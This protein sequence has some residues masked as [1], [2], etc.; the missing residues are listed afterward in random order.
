MRSCS[1]PVILLK[2][3]PDFSHRLSCNESLSVVAECDSPKFEET[4]AA[5]KLMQAT[6]QNWSGSCGTVFYNHKGKKSLFFFFYIYQLFWRHILT[7]VPAYWLGR[8]RTGNI[9]SDLCSLLLA[10]IMAFEFALFSCFSSPSPSPALLKDFVFYKSVS[11]AL[12]SWISSLICARHFVPLKLHFYISSQWSYICRLLLTF[13]LIK[14][15]PFIIPLSYKELWRWGAQKNGC[16]RLNC[17]GKGALL[18]ANE[19][20][21]HSCIKMIIKNI[22]RCFF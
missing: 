9:L 3:F 12:E 15:N 16:K 2:R 17:L 8:T 1:Y 20:A 22:D 6:E 10:W 7:K 19:D 5:V 4:A 14:L 21:F 18:V 11:L 13:T